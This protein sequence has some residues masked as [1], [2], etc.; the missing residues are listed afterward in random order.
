[1]GLIIA[2][3]VA[4]GLLNM[5]GRKVRQNLIILFLL[6]FSL[7][8][9]MTTSHIAS[10]DSV[11]P[12]ESHIRRAFMSSEMVAAETVSQM[13]GLAPGQTL[14]GDTKIYADFLY[15]LL[16]EYEFQMPYDRVED[17]SPIYK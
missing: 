9:I 10:V 12:W 7:S 13:A 17:A 1:M 4:Y 2:V 3:P 14:Q 5:L 6:V 11:I 8:G 16:L 15:T